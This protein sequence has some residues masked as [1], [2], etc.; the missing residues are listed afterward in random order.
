MNIKNLQLFRD[1]LEEKLKEQ[2]EKTFKVALNEQLDSLKEKEKIS[3]GD[4]LSIFSLKD[5]GRLSS[6]DNVLN[7]LEDIIEKF[8]LISIVEESSVVKVNAPGEVV[9]IN[10]HPHT[11]RWSIC[12]SGDF[13]LL[14][15]NKIELLKEGEGVSIKGGVVVTKKNG[16][17]YKVLLSP[18]KK[19]WPQK[20]LLE[21]IEAA[22]KDKKL[23][24][25]KPKLRTQAEDFFKDD[26]SVLSQVIQAINSINDPQYSNSDAFYMCPD[27]INFVPDDLTKSARYEGDCDLN[28]LEDAEQNLQYKELTKNL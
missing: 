18:H 2:T 5:P 24:E 3:A 9:V 27:L 12:N 17:Y 26:P 4:V 15:Q 13:G 22:Q 16:T 8:K 21:K 10:G 14:Y 25:V 11:C 6:R 20:L 19:L 1:F 7:M 28:E 23:S